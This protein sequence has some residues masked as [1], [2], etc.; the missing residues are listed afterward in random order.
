MEEVFHKIN[1]STFDYALSV[2][3]GEKNGGAC[4][5]FVNLG[6]TENLATYQRG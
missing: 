6:F 2:D 5:R 4:E 3:P 1:H